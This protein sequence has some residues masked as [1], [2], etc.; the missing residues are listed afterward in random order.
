MEWKPYFKE[1][2]LP[3]DR[4]LLARVMLGSTKGTEKKKRTPNQAAESIV[5]AF[6]R[7]FQSQKAHTVMRDL[8]FLRGLLK[9][10]EHEYIQV[11]RVLYKSEVFWASLLQ[12]MKRHAAR[13]TDTTRMTA[14]SVNEAMSALHIF[15]I[16]RYFPEFQEHS[17]VLIYNWLAGGLFEALEAVLPAIF[18]DD[19]GIST[20]PI[21]SLTDLRQ[22]NSL[23]YSVYL[24]HIHG[25]RPESH[26]AQ[27][28]DSS[29]ASVGAATAPPSECADDLRKYGQLRPYAVARP[30]A[31]KIV[32][33]VPLRV[34]DPRH[35]VWAQG[36]WQCLMRIT[37]SMR[38]WRGTCG[39]RGCDNPA[40]EGGCKHCKVTPYCS[41]D[42][43]RR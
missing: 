14:A 24:R 36:A 12:F 28:Q 11:F 39:K 26:E 10:S 21:A 4:T 34:R 8:D 2:P 20:F 40:Y 43:L 13:G 42:C 41:P 3:D 23:L 9:A 33:Q 15:W 6:A 29:E 35:Q 17:E 25:D 27:S 16:I 5:S 30:L 32:D 31:R 7:H 1:H 22:Q 37:F 18:Q 19:R 38:P